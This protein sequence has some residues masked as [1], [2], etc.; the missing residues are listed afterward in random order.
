MIL[1]LRDQMV[2]IAHSRRALIYLSIEPKVSLLC[3]VEVNCRN[4]E[5][6][7]LLDQMVEMAHSRRAL[8]CLPSIK[9]QVS[10]LCRVEVNFVR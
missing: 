7:L 2:E 4:C 5:I 3:R 8:I 10:L 9:P 1:L 6:I